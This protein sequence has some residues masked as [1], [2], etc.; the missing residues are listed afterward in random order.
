MPFPLKTDTSTT[1]AKLNVLPWLSL[2]L[3]VVILEWEKIPLQFKKAV[4]T[5]FK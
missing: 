1:S 2:L 4:R 3:S 5:V